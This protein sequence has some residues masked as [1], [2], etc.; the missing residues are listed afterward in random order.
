M[1]ADERQ[2]AMHAVAER[3]RRCARLLGAIGRDRR[4]QRVEEQLSGFCIL[5]AR[6]QFPGDAEA[7]SDDS[8][9]HTGVDA[10]AQH[11]DAQHADQISA[12]R[13]GAPELLVIAALRIQAHDEGRFVDARRESVNIGG[14]IGASAFLAALDEDDATGVGDV[15]IGQCAQRKQRAEDRVAVV[16]APA[17]HTSGPRAR[18]ASR[19]RGRQ[20]TR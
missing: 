2:F 6:K 13:G 18:Q 16:G 4:M 5:D 7:G 9:R 17:D 10:L 1:R 15:L 12:Q 19:A 11:L 20:P 8:A 3:L 14:Q